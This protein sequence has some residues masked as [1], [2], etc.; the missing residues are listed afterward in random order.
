MKTFGTATSA[1]DEMSLAAVMSLQ[2][3]H[4]HYIEKFGNHRFRLAEK[5]TYIDLNKQK[6]ANT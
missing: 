5:Q 6:V 4:Y 3:L 1:K 2:L